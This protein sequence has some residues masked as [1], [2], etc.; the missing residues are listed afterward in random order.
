MNSVGVRDLR[1]HGGDVIDRVLRGETV[2]IT[3]DGVEVAELCPLRRAAA[4]SAAELIARRRHLPA[5]DPEMLR[6]DIDAVI[7]PAL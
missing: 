5:V 4:P 3:R 7:D 2:V 1:N 6:R